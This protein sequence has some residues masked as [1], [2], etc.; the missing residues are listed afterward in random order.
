[1][2]RSIILYS[3]FID[4]LV[5]ISII[6]LIFHT[7]GY[8]FGQMIQSGDLRLHLNSDFIG[9]QFTSLYSTKFSNNNFVFLSFLPLFNFLELLGY[10][11]SLLYIYFG[12]LILIYVTSK[13]TLVFLSEN[14]NN[15]FNILLI[16]ALCF[17]IS[18]NPS[19]FNRIGHFT[20]LH[21]FVFFPLIISFL[22]Y[23]LKT[24]K[25]IYLI[26][27][28]LSCFF[29]NSAPN[30]IVVNT[31]TLLFFP[32]VYSFLQKET[33]LNFFK[34]YLLLFLIQL[35][36]LLHII[37]PILG[38]MGQQ[39]SIFESP[40]TSYIL[41]SLS[42]NSNFLTSISG[43]NY[44]YD[45]LIKYPF[46]TS[47]G[48]LIFLLGLAICIL[49]KFRFSSLGL[50]ACSFL[51]IYTVI[52]GGYI[53]YPNIFELLL[54]LPVVSDFL[55]VIKDP[56]MYYQYFLY[57]LALII[58]LQVKYLKSSRYLIILSVF[59]FL[60]N[61]FYN[62]YSNIQGYRSFFKFIPKPTEY[63]QFVQ[64]LKDTSYRNLWLP[65]NT[66]NSK[67]YSY[68]IPYFPSPALW[69][70]ENKE[71][72]NY[73]L[74]YSKLIRVLEDEIYI[75]KCSNKAFISWLLKTNR[76]NVVID[77]LT[78]NYPQIPEDNSKEKLKYA[79]EC[80]SSIAS[81]EPF[82]KSNEI[83][84]Y[85]SNLSLDNSFFK[86]K[87]DLAFLISFVESN[88]ANIIYDETSDL[89]S[90]S[91]ERLE[92]SYYILQESYDVN[93]VD[94]NGNTP[95]YKVNLVNMAFG[96]SPKE[97]RGAIIHSYIVYFQY[98]L[99]IVSVVLSVYLILRNSNERKSQ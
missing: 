96:S 15:K 8:V 50:V 43:T 76:I 27:L 67:V 2:K 71:L 90:F 58:C 11:F 48:F 24:K 55:W 94:E 54:Q 18:V 85:V 53:T 68:D 81:I 93:W 63:S 74:E 66:Y 47:I 39:R 35:I 37:F 60:G 70:T 36:S 95:L 51:I 69:A 89:V 6:F 73:T 87:G 98:I 31:S 57:F 4:L 97:Y 75:K 13:Y 38:G 88:P 65:Y 45:A 12:I 42:R 46:N 64:I 28:F 34:S 40:T 79:S 77:N 84:S 52:V 7:T 1:M 32:I 30:A 29:G 86:I 9:N 49:T 99:I 3:L 26:L 80:L 56:N 21:S 23:F 5:I 25:F 82:Y 10:D 22:Y 72:T 59:L 20:I 44:Y 91:I 78:K 62:Y 41:T 19:T 83:V 17:Y 33:L 61:F 16:S 92:E 14:Q